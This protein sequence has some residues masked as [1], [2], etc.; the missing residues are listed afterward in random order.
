M[1]KQIRTNYDV[2]GSIT[3]NSF[4]KSGG[5]ATEYLMADGS[6]S[7]G[8]TVDASGVTNIDEYIE[9]V[10][11]AKVVGGSNITISY[12]DTTGE[13]TINGNALGSGTTITHTQSVGSDTWTFNHNLGV[14]YPIIQV[15]DENNDVIIPLGISAATINTAIITF[16]TSRTGVA[17]AVVGGLSAPGANT[18]YSDVDNEFS[19]SQTITGN[20]TATA[21][22]KNG[23]TS[24][25]VLLGDG[26][27][28]DLSGLTGGTST[29]IT[30]TTNTLPKFNGTGDGLI[31]S[32]LIDDGSTLFYDGIFSA[33]TIIKSG[34]TSNDVLLGDGSTTSLSGITG[35]TGGVTADSVGVNELKDEL[36]NTNATAYSG[37]TIPFGQELYTTSGTY[38]FTAQT[39]YVSVLCIGGGGGGCA[40]SS[41]GDGGGGG[42][43]G[44]K[45]DIYV[46][47]GNTVTVVVGSGGTKSTYNVDDAEDGGDSYFS[48]STL[49]CGFGGGRG[50]FT[51]GGA[52]GFFSGDSGGNGGLGG[53]G[54]SYGGGGG[55]AGGYPGD[56]GAGGQGTYASG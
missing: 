5:T 28:I 43:L 39:Y 46:G 12:N 9:D 45:N 22:I 11:G 17:S 10:I 6:V 24:T 37:S 56:G 52:G 55:G 44:Y 2:K 18:A 25:D 1:T 7:S 8:M 51:T 29:E 15:W 19:T 21:I 13:T 32:N 23:A 42:G 35:A 50:R 30:G 3:A 36:K 54:G 40:Y 53:N 49:V 26:T 4:I 38:T 48:A 20:L 33:T 16:S 34:A 27:T 14:L 31:D 41:G 47:S